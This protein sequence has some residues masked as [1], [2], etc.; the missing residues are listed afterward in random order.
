MEQRVGGLL[1]LGRGGRRGEADVGWGP[2]RV[3]Q[4][5]GSGRAMAVGG[6]AIRE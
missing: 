4:G 5:S 6:N 1:G 3:S 2:A